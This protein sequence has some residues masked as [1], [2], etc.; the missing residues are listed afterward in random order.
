MSNIEPARPAYRQAGGRQGSNFEFHK[1]DLGAITKNAF[2]AT[3]AFF[4]SCDPNGVGEFQIDDPATRSVRPL[5]VSF[6]QAEDLDRASE[7]PARDDL[8]RPVVVD[9]AENPEFVV[10]AL[11]IRQFP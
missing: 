10:N 3:K 1:H 2:I 8:H 9:I 5:N 6:L 7:S 11:G 4:Q